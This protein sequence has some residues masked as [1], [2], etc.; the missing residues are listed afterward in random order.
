MRID[1]LIVTYNSAKTLDRCLKRIKK[2]IPFNKILIGDGG[3]KDETIDI[4]EKH[5]AIVRLFLGKDNMI[6]RIR[7]RLAKIAETPWIIY[8]DS[9]VY[10]L[11][12]WWRYMKKF[13]HPKV[14]M[15]MAHSVPTE[16]LLPNY[17]RWRIRRFGFVTFGNTLCQRKIILECKRLENVHVGEDA[18]YAEHCRKNGYL[19][20]PYPK[21][22][23]FHDRPER[24]NQ[25]F[26]RWGRDMRI[27][28]EYVKFLLRSQIHLRNIIWYLLE[29]GPCGKELLELIKCYLAM[30]RGF[31]EVR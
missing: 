19:V 17:Y 4:A 3:S 13:I 31:I 15:A 5:G 23:V 26:Y 22:L 14:G 28:R 9:D 20:I 8:V 7:Y 30:Y 16:N 25:A 2:E 10:L 27:R 18:I 24:L 6:G 11:P 1:V 12:G 21:P 29:S